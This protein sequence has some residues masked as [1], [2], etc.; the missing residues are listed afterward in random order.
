MAPAG[1]FLLGLLTTGC[2]TSAPSRTVKRTDATDTTASRRPLQSPHSQAPGPSDDGATAIQTVAFAQTQQLP[3]PVDREEIAAPD[4]GREPAVRER[5][6]ISS[7]KSSFPLVIAALQENQIAAGNLLAAWGAFDD[8]V[9]ASIENGPIGFYETYRH[10]AGV[11]SPLYG[12]GELFGG[13]RTGRGNFQPWYKERETNEG[14]E[15]KAG[16]RVPL[17]RDRDIDERRADLWRATYDRRRADPEIRMQLLMFVRDGTIAYWK[18]VA[19]GRTYEI[20]RRALELAETRNS[21]LETKV[22]AGDVDP[23]VLQDNLRAIAKRQAKLIDLRRKEAEAALKL[24]LFYRTELGQPIVLTHED[25][26]QLPIP[27][28]MTEEVDQDVQLALGRRPE[29]AALDALARRVDVD[30]AE[31]QN[32]MLPAL[33]AQLTGSQDVGH[34]ASS[35]RDKS[36]FELEAAVFFDVPVQRR[37]AFGKARAARGKQAQIAAK[38]D[39]TVNKIE[40]EVRAAGVALQAA[41][42]RIERAQESRRL[43]DYIADVERRK[44]EVGQSDLLSLV[45]REQYAIEAAEGEVEALLEYYIARAMYRA[46]T[47]QD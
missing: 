15:F 37:K 31:A 12:G 42:E 17:I 24:S 3:Q 27:D 6:V 43:A 47:A 34:P 22:K 20:G 41:R 40:A 10:A 28:E 11:S 8:K 36:P 18:W 25:I 46:A 14:G 13:Y 44:F 4:A 9:K 32:N 19:A 35:K 23:P 2:A 26:P 5:E 21:Q 30:L 45:L 38:R 29:L 16:F 39:F 33:D 7:I 1:L